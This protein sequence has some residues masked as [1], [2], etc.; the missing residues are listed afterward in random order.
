MS[1]YPEI[2]KLL[3]ASRNVMTPEAYDITY[4]IYVTYKS[5]LKRERIRYKKL[6]ET[7]KETQK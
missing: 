1:D 3:E 2:L 7:Y 6:L 4:K 5:A